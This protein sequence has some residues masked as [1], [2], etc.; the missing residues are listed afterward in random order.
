MENL[1]PEEL[2]KDRANFSF[3]VKKLIKRIEI[4][5][6]TITIKLL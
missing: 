2:V 1:N 5:D 3:L 4:G 6:N